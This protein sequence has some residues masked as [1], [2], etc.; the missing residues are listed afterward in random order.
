MD[1]GLAQMRS[2]NPSPD[3][4]WGL[5]LSWKVDELKPFPLYRYAGLT[6]D[7]GRSM[8]NMEV[9]PFFTEPGYMST[10]W[11]AGVLTKFLKLDKRSGVRVV[12]EI[13]ALGESVSRAHEIKDYNNK[14]TE[15]EVLFERCTHFSVVSST[16]FGRLSS[17]W[18]FGIAVPILYIKLEEMNDWD[19]STRDPR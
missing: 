9:K 18:K 13:M 8:P 5:A 6:T 3:R 7:L 15:K 11:N 4:V 14:N 12:F 17:K 2:Y 16:N 1:K 19:S 10:T